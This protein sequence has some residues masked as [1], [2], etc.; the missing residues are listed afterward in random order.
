M[1]EKHRF[2][3]RKNGDSFVDV[4][5]FEPIQECMRQSL[6][7]MIGFFMSKG[8]SKAHQVFVLLIP[9]GVRLFI[10][11]GRHRNDIAIRNIVFLTTIMGDMLSWSPWSTTPS[12]AEEKVA[13]IQLWNWNAV[14]ESFS[15][16]R[17]WMQ[18]KRKEGLLPLLRM[19]PE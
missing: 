3:T 7:F 9:K 6:S 1:R 18:I 14:T 11:L 8:R 12:P 13:N 10:D 15:N 19:V 4:C 5:S 16:C 2:S 17:V